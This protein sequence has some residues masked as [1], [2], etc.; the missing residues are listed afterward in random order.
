MVIGVTK[1]PTT[2]PMLWF[3]L[4]MFPLFVKAVMEAEDSKTSTPPK[5][6]PAPLLVV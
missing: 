5:A 2:P 3:V 4:D 6:P 1:K